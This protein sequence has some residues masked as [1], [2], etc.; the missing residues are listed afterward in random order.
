M[1]NVY[2]VWCIIQVY[3]VRSMVCDLK[4]MEKYDA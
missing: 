4:C 2:E 3:E 1:I